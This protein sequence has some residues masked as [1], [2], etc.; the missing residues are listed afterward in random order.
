MIH[1]IIK[2]C[3]IPLLPLKCNVGTANRRLWLQCFA[4]W[5]AKWQ[6]PQNMHMIIITLTMGAAD[7]IH[8]EFL[9]CLKFSACSVHR[10]A[11]T[12]ASVPSEG[13]KC[14]YL[15]QQFHRYL[16]TIYI[17]YWFYHKTLAPV[18]IVYSDSTK[19][20]VLCLPLPKH[21]ILCQGGHSRMKLRAL[22][23]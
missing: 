20:G 2:L 22:T 5:N 13:S 18:I 14:M 16:T 6:W 8:V 10:S 4:F 21:N 3:K 11:G 15:Y 7:R 9:V 1:W 23:C 17:P 19:C 12:H